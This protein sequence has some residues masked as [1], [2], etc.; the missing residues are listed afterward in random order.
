L[1]H[2]DLSAKYD[3]LTSLLD[4]LDDNREIAAV[5]PALANA[6]M[7]NRWD[8]PPFDGLYDELV[9]RARIVDF[10]IA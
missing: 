4:A 1:C 9:N 3:S 6:A 7:R 5:A 2:L 10:W 8:S